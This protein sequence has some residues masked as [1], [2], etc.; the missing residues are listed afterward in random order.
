MTAAAIL[1]GYLGLAL[2]DL[3]WGIFLTF[4]NYRWVS[5]RAGQVP[6]ELAGS[7]SPEEAE[8]SAA[9]SLAKMRLSFVAEPVMTAIVLA[10]AV[11]GLFGLLDGLVR[12]VA[13]ANPYWQ[14][15]L[16]LGLLLLAQA[17]LSAPLSLYSTF[18]LERR[19]GFNATSLGTWLLDALKAAAIGIALGLPLLYLLYAFIDGAGPLWWLWAAAAFSAINLVLSIVYPLLISPLFNKF[20]RLPEG[21]L[22]TKIA[23]L[24]A[25]L[26]FKVSGIFVMD[27]SRRSRHS[28]A[29][30]TGLGRAKRI[31]LYD[32][33]VSRMG[34]DELL[35][36][37]AHEI[38]HEK[39]GHVLKATALSIALSFVVFW[40]LDRMMGW[41]ELYA[42][43]GFAQASKHALVL[44]LALVTGPATFFLAPA[45]SAWSR[46][47]EYQADAFAAKAAGPGA[48]A[49][50]LIRLNRENASNLWPQPLYSAWHYSHPALIE[51]LAAIRG[52]RR[53]SARAGRARPPAG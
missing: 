4:L 31:V 8:K 53:Y 10:A 42:A 41:A 51:R 34:E 45:L 26:R 1:T 47:R 32:T 43:F 17:A 30:F 16:F 2:I 23:E 49:S 50:A 20:E 15:A 48:L 46:A 22:A 35:A 44:I 3:G 13:G 52:S 27:G 33:L 14:G 38:G 6:P 24:A 28:N 37:L 7:V 12:D 39:R 40:F 29:Y 9:Y 19:F 18:S 36:V 5:R 11:S 21:E 25:S